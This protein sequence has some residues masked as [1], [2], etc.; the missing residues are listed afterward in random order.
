MT[1]LLALNTVSLTTLI[2]RNLVL[3]SLFLIENRLTVIGWAEKE[4]AFAL[5][6]LCGKLE[7]LILGEAVF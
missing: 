1:F 3:F 6:N 7:L 2:T 5:S 4:F